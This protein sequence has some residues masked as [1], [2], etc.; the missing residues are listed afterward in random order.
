MDKSNLFI[1]G[2]IWHWT[3]PI[4]GSKKEGNLVDLGERTMR[5]D[6]Y[7]L[8]VQTTD[9]IEG[10]SI[11][12]IPLSSSERTDFDVQI[13]LAHVYNRGFSW[14]RV[15]SMFPVHPRC[16]DRYICTV[17]DD[18]MKR[19][20]AEIVKLIL[21]E[22][23]L[24]PVNVLKNI[25]GINMNWRDEVVEKIPGVSYIKENNIRLFVRS[26]IAFDNNSC[27]TIYDIKDKYDQYSMIHDIDISDD[28]VEFMDMFMRVMNIESKRFTSVEKYEMIK[29]R[30][31]KIVGNLY[32]NVMMESH[33]IISDQDIQKPGKWNDDSIL[34]FLKCYR[35][36][37][38]DAV[39]ERFGIKENTAR[40]Y[41]SK[42]KKKY[43]DLM[44]SSLPL[45]DTKD[46][47]YSVSKIANI[48]CDTCR[49]ENMYSIMEVYERDP[50]LHS[51]ESEF[52]KKLGNN[53]YYSLIDFLNIRIQGDEYLIPF[54]NENSN[55]LITWRFFDRT[56]HDRR[57]SNEKNGYKLMETYKEL[58]GS[59]QGISKM[60][61]DNFKFR[62]IGR[63]NIEIEGCEKI[64][65]FISEVFC[66]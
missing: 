49:E 7:V 39:L 3:D 58:F 41:Y 35:D 27:L 60:W 51:D 57:I 6:R 55:N 5:Y 62:V 34:E 16:L 2:Q 36:E 14:A 18:I 66:V 31:I 64:A 17:S 24:I 50:V 1:R 20:D 42:W 21:P 43:A 22:F 9:L 63:M 29:F 47:R 32:I 38:F 19:V 8:I 61:I 37:G 59:N 56:Y 28:I 44:S 12:A 13:P 4:Y 46:I 11:L 15:R 26:H 23:S 48:I 54:L 33:D 45:P 30:G 52:Y 25:T 40:S 65:N 53:I 10:G